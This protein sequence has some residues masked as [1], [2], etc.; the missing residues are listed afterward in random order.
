MIEEDAALL[1]DKS[2]LEHIKGV[3][4]L[5]FM[6]GSDAIEGAIISFFLAMLVY[7]DV[8]VQ[9][10]AEV[11]RVLGKDRLPEL[12]DRKNLPY[13]EGVMN[14]CLRWLPVV[15]MG[16]LSFV[17]LLPILMQHPIALPHKVTQDDEYR[18]YLIPKGAIVMGSAW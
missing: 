14:E 17:L 3:T 13:I 10:Q 7:P 15:P 1:P 9:A 8:Q 16:Q 6:A 4:A 11:D 12:D 18:G 5:V 2:Q